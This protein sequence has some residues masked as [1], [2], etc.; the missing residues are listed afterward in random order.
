[1]SVTAAESDDDGR[2]HAFGLS[3]ELI[4]NA[5]RRGASRAANRTSTALKSSPGTDIYHDGIEDFGRLL[6]PSGWRSV[7]VDQQPRLLHPDGTISFTIA[8]AKNVDHT[9]RLVPRTGRKGPST[10]KALAAPQPLATL[11]EGT[12]FETSEEVV[13][14][15]RASE[16]WLLIYERASHG[17]GLYLEFARPAEMSDGGSVNEWRERIPVQFLDIDGDLS[18]FE[19]PEDDADYDVPIE[20]R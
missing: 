14:T 19:P 17:G 2:L 18:A 11:F 9:N 8:A 5:L 12:D 6:A 1:M 10:R 3:S 13:A 7:L 15:A 4:H 20:P 16:L